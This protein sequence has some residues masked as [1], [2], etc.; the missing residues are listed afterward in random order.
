MPMVT[1]PFCRSTVLAG[2]FCG[3]CG[4]AL[5]HAPMPGAVPTM[6]FAAAPTAAPTGSAPFGSAPFGS[7]PFGSAPF[8]PQ[9]VG[10]PPMPP[11][12]FVPPFPPMPPF[13]P[14][15]HGPRS[16]PLS[17]GRPRRFTGVVVAAIVLVLG[18]VGY[19]AL[20]SSE[21]HTLTGSLSLYDSDYDGSAGSSCSG[22]GGYDDIQSGTQ[23][24][25]TDESGTTV[26][27]DS[28]SSGTY[29]GTSCVFEFTVHDVPK[30]KYYRV[31]AGSDT[32]GGPEY[33]FAEMQQQHWSVQLTLGN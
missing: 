14:H 3:D 4:R 12:G 20:G 28:L 22:S 8:G 11:T 15:T 23:V 9:P 30:A 2:P 29:D 10:A 13:P 19:L 1:C 25:V 32:R 21:H 26:A 31:R 5:T 7:A 6:A 27:T 17:L 33:S 16:T 18:T 24:V